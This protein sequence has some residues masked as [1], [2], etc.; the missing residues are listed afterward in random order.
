MP[1]KTEGLKWVTISEERSDVDNHL[2]TRTEE[3]LLMQG[4]LI[5]HYDAELNSVHIVFAGPIPA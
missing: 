2:I 5:K 3:M 1:I 4:S